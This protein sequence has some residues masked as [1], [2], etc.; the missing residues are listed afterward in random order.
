MENEYSFCSPHLINGEY[1]LWR[2]R[3]GKG[4]LLN[5][6][7]AFLIPFSFLWCGFAS[8]WEWSVLQNGIG[9][10]TLF[11]IPFVCAGVYLV[12][13]RFFHLAWLRKHTYYVITNLKIIRKQGNNVDVLMGKNLPSFTVI[14]Y[15]AD[16]GSIRFTPQEHQGRSPRTTWVIDKS[17]FSLENVPNLTRIQQI[18]TQISSQ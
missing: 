15:E 14:T 9:L 4:K 1:I 8:Y 18:L 13:G 5:K 2:G 10:F 6:S 3:P 11:G 17:C 12:I 16:H 7:D